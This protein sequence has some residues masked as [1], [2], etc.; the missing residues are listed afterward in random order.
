MKTIIL[1]ILS[2]ALSYNG[3]AQKIKFKRVCR[4]GTGN[5]LYW[6]INPDTCTVYSGLKLMGT[7]SP[8][9]PYYKIDSGFSISAKQYE[10]VGA[11][12]PSKKDWSYFLQY[13]A[14][15][16]GDTIE[17]FSDTLIV[18]TAKPE[19]TF[20]DSVSVDPFANVIYI[21]WSS[22]KSPDFSSYYLYNNEKPD[23]RLAEN[24][25]DTFFSHL[26]PPINPKNGVL[27]YDIASADSCDN[28]QVHGSNPHKTMWLLLKI[29]TCVNDV[30]LTWTPYVGWSALDS[31]NVYRNLNNAGFQ[32]LKS[33]PPNQNNYVDKS[34]PNN[35]T[36]AY[37]VRAF[38]SDPIRRI[39]SSSNS[40]QIQSGRSVQP[41]NTLINYISNN[42]ENNLEIEIKPNPLSNYSG[43]DLFKF[44]GL[45]SP[46]KVY[47]FALGETIYEDLST[48]NTIINKY[49]VVSKNTCG[50][51]A[52]SSTKSNNIVLSVSSDKGIVS[53]NW[54]KYFTW[55]D[56][57]KEYIIFSGSG[58]KLSDIVSF[59]A[60]GSS[61]LDT[62]STDG[63]VVDKVVCY[64]VQAIENNNITKS[65]SNIACNLKIGQ[66]YYP[67]AIVLSGVNKQFT[68]KGLGIE[69]DKS[70]IQIFNRWGA[71]VYDKYD[72]TSGWF[73]TD[74][75][76]GVL[77]ED[78]YFFIAKIFQG[79]QIVT[80]NG[81]I[82]VIR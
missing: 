45:Q 35:A 25:L 65:R 69:L 81:N 24:Y 52:D 49:F 7:E 75:N 70:S 32:L 6:Q 44:V 82:T 63:E 8:S 77:D 51:Y 72:I 34:I 26:T 21:G 22:N 78:V 42:S 1:V 64:Y 28:R 48:P 62:F 46:V 50:E 30:T 11:N 4:N 29:D 61:G 55:N 66:V 17:I 20:L 43:V 57:V 31:Q 40:A 80:L 2:F 15:C 56:G 10:H 23:P 53:L 33:I 5:T 38:K 67:N 73:G 60:L 68:F 27:T 3:I 47:S 41:S 76:N 12:I 14:I 79:G 37:Y 36:A 16:N 71:K 74:N 9:F 59:T 19:A 54:N 58:Y 18:D 39:S 13:L